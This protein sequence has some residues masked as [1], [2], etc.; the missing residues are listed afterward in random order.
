M[1]AFRA[2]VTPPAA[3]VWLR[4]AAE[5]ERGR[6]MPWLAVSMIAGDLGYFA[7]LREPAAY[8]GPA[9]LGVAVALS[10]LLRSQAPARMIAFALL[11]AATGFASAQWAASRAPPPL[12]LPRTA[13][14]FTATVAAIEP[15]PEGS[16]LT[17]VDAHWEG[18]TLR[19]ALH[20][21]LRLDD[22]ASL[23]TG[24]TVQ[25]RAV[26]RPPAPARLSRGLG[27]A[28]G[29]LLQ[30]PGR[31]RRRP[32]PSRHP[33]SPTT[34]RPG[35]LAHGTAGD[36]CVPPA[37]RPARRRGCIG[38]HSPDRRGQRHPPRPTAP[39]SATRGWRISWRSPAC[40]SASSWAW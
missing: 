22:P 6:F 32:R 23:A 31:R 39:P 29:R 27:F 11:A 4:E 3:S 38:C 21:R 12:A 28:A 37:R 26:L 24:D 13:V 8:A 20:I 2:F 40:I 34:R 17:L 30:R 36:D 9:L 18:A 14:V 7:L 19:R 10:L 35:A 16:R 33:L 1:S 5:A 25:L 15:R